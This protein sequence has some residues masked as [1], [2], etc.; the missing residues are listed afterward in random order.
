MTLYSKLLN[1]PQNEN[2]PFATMLRVGLL[3][4]NGH[5]VVTVVSHSGFIV[6]ERPANSCRVTD[7]AKTKQTPII[8]W[9]MVR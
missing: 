8:F 3:G 1:G 5:K 6:I 4:Q 7:A 2:E 9:L